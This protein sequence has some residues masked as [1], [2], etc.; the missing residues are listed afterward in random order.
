MPPRKTSPDL[1]ESRKAMVRDV[2]LSIIQDQ[3][4]EKLTMDK[5][6]EKL[7]FSKGTAYKYFSCV[8]DLVVALCNDSMEVLVSYINR[9][10]DMPGGSKEKLIYLNFLF[11]V[12]Y[13]VSAVPLQLVLSAKSPPYMK[14]AS[15]L[16][17]EAHVRIEREIIGT[18][19]G[20]IR[21]CLVDNEYDSEAIEPKEIALQNYY[22]LI[23]G[24]VAFEEESSETSY[25]MRAGFFDNFLVRNILNF[26]QGLGCTCSKSESEYIKAL[27]SV[28]C[29]LA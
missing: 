2:A 27:K 18:L 24:L 25:A 22:I 20:M 4:I 8:E 29:E 28:E 23:G 10:Q 14:K 16:T 17:R 15:P 19:E 12:F 7:P 3:G 6:V 26:L 9:A 5:V 11:V 1:I 21:S 13:K